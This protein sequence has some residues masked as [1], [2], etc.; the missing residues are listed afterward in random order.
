MLNPTPG[1]GRNQARIF[2]SALGITAANAHLLR[3]ALRAA[4]APSDTAIAKGV[5]DSGRSM[6]SGFRCGSRAAQQRCCPHG[7]FAAESPP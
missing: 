5:T 7:L 2:E 1:E 4:P 3:D 6:W